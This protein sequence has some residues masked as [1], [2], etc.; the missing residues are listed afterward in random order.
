MDEQP[1]YRKIDGGAASRKLWLSVFTQVLI[2]IA[3]LASTAIPSLQP[4][5]STL[6]G[7]LV[8]VLALYIGGNVG[9]RWVHSPDA[10][11]DKPVSA[12]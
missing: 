9:T 12:P 5:F 3:A 11:A 2:M 6:S 7:S 4:L 8:G 1:D 10:T